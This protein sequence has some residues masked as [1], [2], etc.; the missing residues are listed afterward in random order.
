M[1]CS[2]S[3]PTVDRV[4]VLTLTQDGHA[5]GDGHNLIELMGDDDDCTALLTHGAQ[6]I[7]Q[8]LGLLRCQDGGG[9][10]QNQ[11]ALAADR[12]P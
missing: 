9:L 1:S 10:V 8:A 7:K 6:N 11:D 4:D 5:V 3:A 12:A 2:S